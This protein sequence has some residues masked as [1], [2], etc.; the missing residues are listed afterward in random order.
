MAAR[1]VIPAPT[2]DTESVLVRSDLQTAYP[3]HDLPSVGLG[4]GVKVDNSRDEI[5][6]SIALL[7]DT[8]EQATRLRW[9]GL[10]TRRSADTPKQRTSVR[11]WYLDILQGRTKYLP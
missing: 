8:A 4:H 9:D 1:A 10:K 11:P 5:S 7:Q 3:E 2:C 6:H